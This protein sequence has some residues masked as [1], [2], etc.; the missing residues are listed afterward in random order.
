MSDPTIFQTQTESP[1]AP[2]TDNR[3]PLQKAAALFHK[4]TEGSEPDWQALLLNAKDGAEK[5]KIRSA[6]ET[7]QAEQKFIAFQEA[8]AAEQARIEQVMKSPG[9]NKQFYEELQRNDPRAYWSVPVQ[10]QIKADRA[11]MGLSYYLK[12]PTK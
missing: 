5:M 9:R 8:Q 4:P 10:R 1:E 6:R 3:D 7:Y 2:K 11:K 12:S